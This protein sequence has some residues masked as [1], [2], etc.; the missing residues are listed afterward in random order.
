M[1]HLRNNSLSA[2]FETGEWPVGGLENYTLSNGDGFHRKYVEF[3]EDL[4]ITR[5]MQRICCE[6][7]L[8]EINHSKV[9]ESITM[10]PMT[11]ATVVLN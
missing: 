10:L 8:D 3:D 6:T 2:V 5:L 9:L 7:I 1:S 4:T 11:L